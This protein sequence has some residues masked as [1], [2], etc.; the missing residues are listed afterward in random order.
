MS[1]YARFFQVT[2]LFLTTVVVFLTLNGSAWGFSESRPRLD[3]I[4][5]TSERTTGH[6]DRTVVSWTT[7]TLFELTYLDEFPQIRPILAAERG[8]FDRTQRTLKLRLKK[9]LTFSDGA[10]I[11]AKSFVDS[12]ENQKSAP[13]SSTVWRIFLSRIQSFEAPNDETLIIHFFQPEPDFEIV[14]T[15]PFT[16]PR[17]IG[18]SSANS[19]PFTLSEWQPGY[20]LI[21]KSRSNYTHSFF[22]AQASAEFREAGY[23]SQSSKPLPQIDGIRVDWTENEA[24]AWNL[25][26]EGK[27]DLVELRESFADQVVEPSKPWTLQSSIGASGVKLEKGWKP[28]FSLALLN[29]KTLEETQ[30]RKA[31]LSQL[32]RSFWAEIPGFLDSSL[33]KVETPAL[34]R[35]DNW[36]DD[37]IRENKKSVTQSLKSHKSSDQPSRSLKTGKLIRLAV[38][39]TDE[40]GRKILERAHSRLQSGGFSVESRTEDLQAAIDSFK[41]GELDV[42]ILGWTWDIPTL[43]NVIEPIFALQPDETRLQSEIRA[44]NSL[45][46]P[47]SRKPNPGVRDLNARLEKLAIWSPGPRHH[48]RVLVQPW[49]FGFHVSSAWASPERYLWIDRELRKNYLKN[50]S[51]APRF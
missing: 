11:T 39:G 3:V 1:R 41:K 20:G 25:F 45:S 24:A 51:S 33:P 6:D 38:V 27:A 12:W 47:S 50:T 48:R 29:L 9:G 19:G 4:I 15:R 7:D 49:I 30:I 16:A 10:S 2:P 31:I 44:L 35:L 18:Q 37:G 14:L 43:R 23:L 40:Q 36:I 21:L 34:P 22:P 32:D 26:R 13:K 42:I 5:A 46:R 8:E 17:P 28:T